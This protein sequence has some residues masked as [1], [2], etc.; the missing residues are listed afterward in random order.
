MLRHHHIGGSCVS[1]L[2]FAWN[3]FL[4]Q[5]YKVVSDFLTE[6]QMTMSYILL[7]HRKHH[8]TYIHFKVWGSRI[9]K[10]I[11]DTEVKTTKLVWSRTSLV[12]VQWLR[13]CP[14]NAGGMTLIP[15][16]GSKIHTPGSEKKKNWLIHTAL[17]WI[18]AF[19]S[20]KL[21]IL[22]INPKDP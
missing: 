4:L 2:F 19:L 9:R 10:D 1:P 18:S 8:N 12:V 15:D 13:L 16:V 11:K 5:I 20:V 17:I 14:S 7:T 21:K 3:T 22:Y 6:A